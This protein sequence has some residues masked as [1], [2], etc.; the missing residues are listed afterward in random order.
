MA[1]IGKLVV[2]LTTKTSKFNKGLKRSAARVSAFATDIGG[3]IKRIARF[4]A[5][6]TAVA[7]GAIAVF[8]K[9]AFESV[10]AV[11]KLAR[12]VGASIDGLRGLQ[13]A[14]VLTGASSEA[15]AKALGFMTKALGEAKTGIG[16]GKQALELLGLSFEDLIALPAE[17]AVGKIADRMN[18]LATQSE[19]AFVASKLFGRGG[20]ALINTLALGSKGLEEMAQGLKIL[21]GSMSDVD[22]G[23]IEK[24]NDA[25]A[26]MQ[27]SFKG[28][29]ERVAVNVA[30]FVTNIAE[31]M[32]RLFIFI[33]KQAANAVPAILA[34]FKSIVAG[35]VAFVDRIFDN[36]KRIPASF[37]IAAL[38]I[39]LE[40]ENLKKKL[41]VL[42]LKIA[43]KFDDVW[44][45]I[46]TAAKVVALKM[47]PT[48]IKAFVKIGRKAVNI[49][50]SIAKAVGAE[51]FAEKLTAGAEKTFK[52]ITF[53]SKGT[54]KFVERQQRAFAS[55]TRTRND[56]LKKDLK[57][58]NDQ[59]AQIKKTLTEKQAG[60]LGGDTGAVAKAIDSI[61]ASIRDIELPNLTEAMKKGGMAAAE[62][63][64]VAVK[65][66]AALEKG[67]V[68]AASA[69][70][71]GLGSISE[72][73]KKTVFEL[74]KGNKLQLQ[75]NERLANIVSFG[76][77][78]IV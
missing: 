36:V 42:G 44:D 5:V 66:P 51:D 77:V 68:A 37:E 63:I 30:P 54:G 13:R 78:E 62:A 47:T 31:K 33:R 11:A 19:K 35:V 27:L 24:A 15:V 75:T 17:E 22:A 55:R 16:E 53:L 49:F 59:F 74:K 21:Q 25:V 12:Q 40:W 1:T 26:D 2:T 69:T 60:L 57:L 58:V 18:T 41:A 7:V 50:S 48:F 10:D 39:V 32:T 38:Q 46:S 3:S 72:N 61:I 45:T 23:K 56:A 52:I 73:S 67:T 20:L 65:R 4:G 6:M 43:S 8:T 76:V 28:L 29:F 64:G 70:V 14:A 34:R 9:R 71:R